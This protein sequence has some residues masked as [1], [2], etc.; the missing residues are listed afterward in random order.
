M[1]YVA[2]RIVSILRLVE[3]WSKHVGKCFS[4]R[5]RMDKLTHASI[6]LDRDFYWLYDRW[7]YSRTLGWRHDLLFGSAAQRGRRLR[8]IVARVASVTMLF[9][10]LRNK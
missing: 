5:P 2:Y 10:D 7:A 8:R 3:L 1:L 6:H 4:T 9:S